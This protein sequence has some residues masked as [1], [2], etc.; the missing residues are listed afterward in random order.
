MNEPVWWAFWLE[1]HRLSADNQYRPIIGQFAD[2]RYQPFDN[3]HRP[4]IGIGSASADYRHW[5][6]IGRLFVLVSKTT[7]NKHRN[8][9][10]RAV[11]KN[12]KVNY[13][14]SVT[15]LRLYH[16]DFTI[17]TVWLLLNEDASWNKQSLIG[18]LFGADNRPAD[19]RPKHYRCTS[20]FDYAC[21]VLICVL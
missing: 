19:N 10:G 1:V 20:N 18:R 5:P 11:T 2:N 12:Y 13:G 17:I 16:C 8:G 7:K 21:T 4:I 15:N 9:L 14:R 6:I 3:R